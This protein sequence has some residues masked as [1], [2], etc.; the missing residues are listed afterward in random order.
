MS[1]L[2]H[3]VDD[4]EEQVVLDDAQDVERLLQGD[5]AAGIG[6]QLVEDADGVAEAAPGRPGDHRERRLGHLDALP[7]G[8]AREHAHHLAD[9]RPAEVEAL[10]ARQD[11]GRHLVRLGG[12]EDEDDVRRRLLEGLQQ[13]V[14]GLG[15]SMCTSSMM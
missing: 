5:R 13:R 11:G 10:A 14:E 9:G 4:L 2:V 1:L 6:G 3:H 12:G 7:R 15:V 8:D